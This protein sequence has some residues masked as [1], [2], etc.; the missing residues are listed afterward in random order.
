MSATLV[1]LMV[2]TGVPFNVW[3]EQ[4]DGVIETALQLISDAEEGDD[5]PP[6]TGNTVWSG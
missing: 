2:R 1:A 4:P 3:L 5:D 6:S